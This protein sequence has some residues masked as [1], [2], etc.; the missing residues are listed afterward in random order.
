MADKSMEKL[1]A[2]QSQMKDIMKE[3][4]KMKKWM[5]NITVEAQTVVFDECKIEKVVVNQ[6]DATDD[7]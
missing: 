4:S 7:K 3:I 1:E 6:P 5:D 2:I